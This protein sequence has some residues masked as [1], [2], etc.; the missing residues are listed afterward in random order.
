VLIISH[1]FASGR[2]IGGTW[3]SPREGFKSLRVIGGMPKQEMGYK[4]NLFKG[5]KT[6]EEAQ[7][8]YSM[9]PTQVVVVG[10]KTSSW[11]SW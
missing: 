11:S 4:H 6:W 7:N 8:A 10:S 5:Y 3:C 9:F 1:I 2:N